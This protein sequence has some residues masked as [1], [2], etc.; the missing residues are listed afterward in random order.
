MS[1]D[2][3]PKLTPAKK[4]LGGRKTQNNAELWKRRTE[5]FRLYSMG[6]NLQEI[7]ARFG[8]SHVAIIDDLKAVAMMEK[9]IEA[10]HEC[11]QLFN[12]ILQKA[13]AAYN[14]AVTQTE[15]M[16]CLREAMEANTRKAKL[17]GIM[18]DTNIT[19]ILNAKVSAA[20]ESPN[21][22]DKKSNGELLNIIKRRRVEG[23]AR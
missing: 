19:N 6:F 22:Y 5:E 4:R 9:P 17:L 8:V 11:G 21:G 10:V 14:N 13:M 1:Q 20:P 16:A 7:A 3:N 2:S 15:K 23:L 12:E 18:S